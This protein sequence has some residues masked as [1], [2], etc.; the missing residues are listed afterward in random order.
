MWQVDDILQIRVAHQLKQRGLERMVDG[1]ETEDDMDLV[2]DPS[3]QESAE[4]HMADILIIR[5]WLED[6]IKL[7]VG[8]QHRPAWPTKDIITASCS[9]IRRKNRRP[10][11]PSI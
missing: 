10:G 7:E 8:K 2:L 4:H 11:I 3:R 5:G 1:L 9:H 6:A